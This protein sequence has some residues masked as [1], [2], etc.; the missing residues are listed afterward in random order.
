MSVNCTSERSKPPATLHW[1]ING[2]LVSERRLKNC[3]QVTPF[4][5][6]TELTH[7]PF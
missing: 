5:G 3:T 4:L 2:E 7:P 6:A 1:Y